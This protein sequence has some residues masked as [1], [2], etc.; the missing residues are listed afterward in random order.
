MR[1]AFW[2]VLALSA[3]IKLALALAFAD[4]QPRYD[5]LEFFQFGRQIAEG[6]SG[7]VVWRAPGYQLFCAAGLVL[8]GGEMLGIRL[9]Q[10]L[11]SIASTLLVMRIGTRLH[12]E[13]AGY[14]AGIAVALYPTHIALSH[15]L[16]AETLYIFLTLFGLDR[17]LTADETGSRRVAAWAG[18]G[19]GA[20]ALTRSTGLALLL[21]STLWL[22]RRQGRWRSGLAAAC[23][24]GSLL[25]LAPWAT[26]ATIQAGR[27]VVVDANAG[28]NLWS[29]NNP[30]IPRDVQGLWSLGL[31]PENGNHEAVG[32]ALPHD[33]WWGQLGHDVREAGIEPSLPARDAWLRSQARATILENPVGFLARAPLKLAA[34]W[35]PDFFVP[36][37]LVRG[38]YGEIPSGLALALIALVWGAAAVALIGG[39][40]AWAVLP[41]SRPRLLMLGWIAVYLAVHMLAYGHTRLH[42]PLVPLMLLAVAAAWCCKLSGRAW[43]RR[44][45]A[46]AALALGVWVLAL[47]MVAGIYLAPS[48]DHVQ[49]ARALGFV[50]KLPLPAAR[51]VGWSLAA[52]EAAAGE[53]ERAHEILQ[54][55]GQ[56]DEGW[57]RYLRS[58]LVADPA[59]RVQ[60]LEESV[61]LDPRL[62]HGWLEL[63]ELRFRNGDP[64]GATVALARAQELRPWDRR[65]RNR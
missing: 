13:G 7:P 31:N 28:Y 65:V 58:R 40:A 43:L 3:V 41:A 48:G 59:V 55:P 25:L 2:G 22:L 45:A 4:L 53:T 54:E 36:R 57:A 18:L 61:R 14:L 29:G 20:A 62:F 44:G 50:R 12:S 33:G 11:A 51:W 47:P 49:T 35:A 10:V 24:A 17:L 63:A 15:L 52:A 21:L 26:Y 1:R 23:V 34:F 16:W 19:L 9:L 56:Q 64:Q 6:E 5:E 32:Y 38:W 8:S 37:H 27:L 60:L 30:Y 46:P 39:P 42:Q